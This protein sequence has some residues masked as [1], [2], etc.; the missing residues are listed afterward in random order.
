MFPLP[1]DQTTFDFFARFVLAGFIVIW[2]RSAFVMGERP[3]LAEMAVEAVL[4]SLFNQLVFQLATLGMAHLPLTLPPPRVLLLLE[5]V[6]LPALIG[7]AFGLS[8]SRGWNR[9]ILNRLSMPVQNPIRRAH[10]FAFMRNAT[11]TF[12]IVTYAD[13]SRVHGFYG[14]NSLASND[15]ARS[16][17]YLERLYAVSEDGQWYEQAPPRSAL[18]TLASVRSIEFLKDK[19]AKDE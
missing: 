10:D 6:A 2:T 19:G 8:L 17:L 1:T 12:V 15:P 5:V 16:D 7:T 13:G 14:Q 11:E 3:R 18:L 9:A 4:L